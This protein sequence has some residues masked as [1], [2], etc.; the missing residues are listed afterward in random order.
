MSKVCRL[1]S[2][3]LLPAL[4]TGCARVSIRDVTTLMRPPR[5]P[6]ADAR[7]IQALLEERYGGEGFVAFKQ[8]LEGGDAIVYHE[9]GGVRLA[10]AFFCVESS[11]PSRGAGMKAALL[12]LEDGGW[13]LLSEASVEGAQALSAFAWGEGVLFYL[14]K[15]P[16]RAGAFR[17]DGERL[18]PMEE[19]PLDPG[20]QSCGR[21]VAR[22][23]YVLFDADREDGRITGLVYWDGDALRT[24][25]GKD[26]TLR[27][28]RIPMREIDGGVYIPA[29]YVMPGAP[30]SVQLVR[31]SRLEE[32]FTLTPVAENRLYLNTAQWIQLPGGLTA[33]PD[34]EDPQTLRFYAYENGQW[35]EELF[36]LFSN[37]SESELLLRNGLTDA[38]EEA[39]TDTAFLTEIHNEEVFYEAENTG[40]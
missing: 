11:L 27:T 10:A 40:S 32:D 17:Y 33:R 24:A 23:N 5:P 14:L 36:W 35:G 19:V 28:L 29:E 26:E 2:I 38:G 25:L 12:R 20:A 8:P 39:G 30:E 37:G 9:A 22:G 34:A 18:L 1:I 16:N 7:A 3:I 15:D 31:W 13:R 21:P 6:D 4:L